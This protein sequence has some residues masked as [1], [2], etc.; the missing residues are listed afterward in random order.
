MGKKGWKNKRIWCVVIAAALLCVGTGGYLFFH[1]QAQGILTGLEEK[2][3]QKVKDSKKFQIVEVV[4]DGSEGEIGYLVKNK[5]T[6][7]TGDYLKK[8]LSC[9]RYVQTEYG[10]GAKR[11]C[12]LIDGKIRSL[13]RRRKTIAKRRRL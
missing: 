10:T 7:I 2:V 12:Q 1:V 11:L 13:C 5:D 3:S 9:R 6:D 4:P 8:Y